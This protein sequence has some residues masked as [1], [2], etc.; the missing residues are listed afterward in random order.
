MK[1]SQ[2]EKQLSAYL[3]DEL[4]A[5][6]REVVEA[7]L[8]RCD[9]CTQMLSE[10]RQYS[11]LFSGLRQPTPSSIWEQLQDRISAENVG[12]VKRRSA[13]TWW[14]WIF[15]PVSAG[16]GAIAAV[17]LVLALI[18]FNPTQEVYEDPL[19]LYLM[20]HTEY[21]AYDSYDQ[22]ITEEASTPENDD[23]VSEDTQTV[24][25]TY[26]DAYFGE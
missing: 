13:A 20:V 4:S 5:Q 11:E 21:A 16:V 9:A 25:D 2:I 17:C 26:L 6:E 15:R 1:H 7:H 23:A 8:D 18:Y 19:N 3:D 12:E 24:L 14:G 10:L 22:S